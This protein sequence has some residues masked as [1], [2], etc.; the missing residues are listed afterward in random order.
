VYAKTLASNKLGLEAPKNHLSFPK[1]VSRASKASSASLYSDSA[2]MTAENFKSSCSAARR[3]S[4]AIVRRT[5]A[6]FEAGRTYKGS[7]IE[8]A[9]VDR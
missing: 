5:N 7:A 2:F 6:L 4:C 1:R 3:R 9:L 8:V